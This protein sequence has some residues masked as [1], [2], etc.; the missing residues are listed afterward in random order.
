LER[1]A[2]SGVTPILILIIILT[3]GFNVQRAEIKEKYDLTVYA[4]QVLGETS[5]EKNQKAR[6]LTG[7]ISASTGDKLGVEAG[8]WIK[9][10]YMVT[11]APS[12]ASLPTA[13]KV[14]FLSV[15]GINVTVRVTIY[16]SDGTE[17]N[18]TMTMDVMAGGGTFGN[19]SGSIIPAN[20][21]TGDSIYI[22]GYGNITIAGETR[23]TYA[24]AERTV[25]YAT[26]SQGRAR[27]YWDKQTGVMVE[28]SVS[29]GGR[30]ATVKA[31]ET[32]M[33]GLTPFWMQWWFWAIVA[34]GMVILVRAVYLKKRNPPTTL[35]FL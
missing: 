11:G 7:T 35:Y 10:N 17:R 3:L 28:A 6:F 15:E 32:N 1:K 29:S 26:F 16:M 30:T 12:G 25:V 31:I 33:W 27:Y 18:Q 22:N 19:F 21:A 23:R 2:A 4:C 8:N 13:M 5:A 24:G 34:A 9:F 20:S 14:E